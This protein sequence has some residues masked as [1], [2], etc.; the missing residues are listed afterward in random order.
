MSETGLNALIQ[1]PNVMGLTGIWLAG[2][3]RRAGWALGVGSEVAWGL[4]AWLDHAWGLVP[5]AVGWGVVYARNWWRW[6]Q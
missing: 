6:R 3:K 4:W 5:W 2:K 1:L